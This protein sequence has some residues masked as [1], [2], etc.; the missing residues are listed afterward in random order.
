M[1][2]GVALPTATVVVDELESHGLVERRP[3]PDDR[4]RELVALTAAGRHA[5]ATIDTVLLRPTPV[6][7]R[8]LDADREQAPHCSLHTDFH[9]EGIPASPHAS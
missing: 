4:R 3:H 8:L 7:R 1:A 5:G 6:L 2:I 9:Q